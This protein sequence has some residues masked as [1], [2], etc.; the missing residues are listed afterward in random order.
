MK[1]LSKSGANILTLTKIE[2]L[3]PIASG[4]PFANFFI[5]ENIYTLN[6][7]W[8]KELPKTILVYFYQSLTRKKMISSLKNT[9]IH[10]HS[11]SSIA[12]FMP[13]LNQDPSLT[14]ALKKNY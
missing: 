8:K 11:Q 10:W 13:F 12:S 6:Q 7:S 2:H 3:S 1:A 5:K 4:I 14:T 9:L